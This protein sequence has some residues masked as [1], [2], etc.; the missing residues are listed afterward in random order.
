MMRLNS[1]N[2]HSINMTLIS[3]KKKEKE[4]KTEVIQVNFKNQIK[5]NFKLVFFF[6]TFNILT[7]LG[8]LMNAKAYS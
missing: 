2:F 4:N 6:K 7:S 5:L 8:G 1:K 3:E